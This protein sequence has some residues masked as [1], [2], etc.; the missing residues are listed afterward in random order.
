MSVLG[1]ALL[2]I[3]AAVVAVE[4]FV[5][6]AQRRSVAAYRARVLAATAERLADERRQE[7]RR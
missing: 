5:R 4:L 7:V 3:G 1:V 2:L 6:R